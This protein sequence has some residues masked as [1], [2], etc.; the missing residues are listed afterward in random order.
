MIKR[1]D[2][3]ILAKYH[4]GRLIVRKYHQGRLYYDD[5]GWLKPATKQAILGAFGDDGKAVIKA[6]NAYL[7]GIAAQGQAG[8]DKAT[9]LAANFNVWIPLYVPEDKDIMYSL[10]PT[11]GKRRWLANGN[12]GAYVKT[13]IKPT[14]NSTVK[15]TYK[16]SVNSTTYPFVFG[17]ELASRSS[18]FGTWS[19]TSTIAPRFGSWSENI[20]RN[21]TGIPVTVE[22]RADGKGYIDGVYRADSV[23]NE[24]IN[25]EVYLYAMNDNDRGVTSD[26]APMNG[27]ICEFEMDGHVFIP[28]RRNNVMEWIDL[29]TGTL[30][31]RVGTFTE[32]IEPTPSTP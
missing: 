28:I 17:A 15:I 29:T 20:A 1:M 23:I 32:V 25:F 7:N 21:I 18:R 5:P 4:Q 16:T 26:G 9:A 3:E 12:T 8:K 11:L 22:R 31:T 14:K 19:T 30:A 27:A 24:D 2:K 6:T 10:V 13:G